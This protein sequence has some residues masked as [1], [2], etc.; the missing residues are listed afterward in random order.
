MSGSDTQ[1]FGAVVVGGGPAGAAVSRLLSQWGHRV[2]VLTRRP[3]DHQPLAVSIPPSSRRLLDVLGVTDVVETAGFQRS[4]GN[5]VWW[6]DT[7]SRCVD[8]PDGDTGFQVLRSELEA[9]LLE[10]SAGA[11]AQVRMDTTVRWVDVESRP[12]RVGF[13]SSDGSVGTLTAGLVLDCSGRTGV[14]AGPLRIHDQANATVALCGVWRRPGGWDLPDDTHTLVESY[15]DG[16]AWSIPTAPGVR[17]VTLMVDPRRT[18]MSRGRERDRTYLAELDKTVH[19]RRLV[20][21]ARFDGAVWGHTAS[22]YSA[23]RYQDEAFLLVGDAASFIDPLSSFGVKKALASAWLAAVVVNTAIRTPS[24][25]SAAGELYDRRERY[26]WNTY[27]SLAARFYR[28]AAEAHGHAFWSAR[29]E[30]AREPTG[31]ATLESDVPSL[32]VPDPLDVGGE[33]DV[34]VLRR[35]PAVLAAFD[36]LRQAPEIRLSLGRNVRRSIGAAVRGRLVVPEERLATDALPEGLRY[37]RGV[38]LIQVVETAPEHR[39]VPDLWEAYCRSAGPVI[40]PDFIGVL[41]VL[42]ARGILVNESPI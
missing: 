38:D 2:C 19:V 24:M 27:R 28:D 9:L 42:L 4:R 12:A 5:T 26:V 34:E 32:D 16:W 10:Q 36:A 3:P 7:A 30:A 29:S 23:G 25:A 40:L 35:D 6:G 17:F 1:D 21:A 18:V 13:E 15:R 39:Q 22:Q 33:P 37:V 20:D 41:S 31:A 8:F 14:V 11:G